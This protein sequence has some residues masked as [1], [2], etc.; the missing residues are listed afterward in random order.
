MSNTIR[1]LSDYTPESKPNI[2]T[3]H[4]D[5]QGDIHISMFE[6]KRSEGERGVRIAASG[7]RHSPRVREAFRALILAYQE[8]LADKGCRSE[9]KELNE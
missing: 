4:A 6:A 1:I 9:L 8:E 2:L 5:D 3:I 7:T